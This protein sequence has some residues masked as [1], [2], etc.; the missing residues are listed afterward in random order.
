MKSCDLPPPAVILDVVSV[1]MLAS[2][3][4][5]VV[6]RRL[7]SSSNAEEWFARCC[8]GVPWVCTL[9]QMYVST[10]RALKILFT[11]VETSCEG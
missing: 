8:G 2:L 5:G 7:L 1:D 10:S 6:R 11:F 9:R 3:V 4:A